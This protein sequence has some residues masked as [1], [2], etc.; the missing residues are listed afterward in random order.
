MNQHERENEHAWALEMLALEEAEGPF[1][2]NGAAGGAGASARRAAEAKA[3]LAMRARG[4]VR[5]LARARSAS[6]KHAA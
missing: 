2:P 6:E 3:S 5:F 4:R 1:L